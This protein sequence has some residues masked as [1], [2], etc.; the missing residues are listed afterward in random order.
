MPCI[1]P[2]AVIRQ[3]DCDSYFT[4]PCS[5]CPKSLQLQ[6]ITRASYANVDT[7]ACVAFGISQVLF[8]R[9]EQEVA[10]RYASTVCRQQTL[11]TKQSDEQKRSDGR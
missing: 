8:Q 2:F 3:V 1:L 7:A 5:H 6:A 11:H 9:G 10:N 4:S